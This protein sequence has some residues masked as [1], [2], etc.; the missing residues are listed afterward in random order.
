MEL[1]R[2]A[3]TVV[4]L[5][6]AGGFVG[7]GP[8]TAQGPLDLL[9]SLAL[10]RSG[11]DLGRA[12]V[13]VQYTAQGP[14]ERTITGHEFLTL[15]EPF[16]ARTAAEHV[17]SP[18]QAAAA[19]VNDRTIANRLGWPFCD[20]ASMFVF[21]IGSLEEVIRHAELAPLNMPVANGP[22]C[23]GWYGPTQTWQDVTFVVGE[24]TPVISPLC[25][26]GMLPM[27]PGVPGSGCGGTVACAAGTGALYA[28]HFFGLSFAY[29]L[30]GTAYVVLGSGQVDVPAC[31]P[32]LGAPE[33]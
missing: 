9:T 17:V 21:Y 1:R 2:A 24:D 26:Q 31:A 16:L 29:F 15:A 14:V 20:Y 32:G 18:W 10:E 5:L 11:G 28:A 23:D 19:G 30:G 27:A 3:M 8:A 22:I 4:L 6:V 12:G 13:A 25:V 33:L 7:F